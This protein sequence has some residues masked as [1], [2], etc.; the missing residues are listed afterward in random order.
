MHNICPSPSALSLG[1]PHQFVQG[2]PH[3]I[4]GLFLRG[5]QGGEDPLPLD[6]NE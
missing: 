3:S 2:L 5:A 6:R 1:E 4:E